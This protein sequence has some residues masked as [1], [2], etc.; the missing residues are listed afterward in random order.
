MKV[1]DCT[2]ELDNLGKRTVEVSVEANELIEENELEAI[3][4]T[5]QY[6]VLKIAPGN[7]DMNILMSKRQYVFT[8][9][10]FSIYKKLDSSLSL[11]EN[12]QRIY[13][14]F[15]MREVSSVSDVISQLSLSMFRTDRIWIDPDFGPEYSLRRYSNWIKTDVQKM[16]SKLY[17]LI[18]QGKEVGFCMLQH[19][20]K[21]MKV[22]LDGLYKQYQGQGLGCLLPFCGYYYKENFVDIEDYVT[23]ISS[24]NLGVLHTYNKCDFNMVG[25]NYVF[26]KH[27]N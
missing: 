3:E 12:Q 6:V 18:Y 22:V 1:V 17:S 4:Q 24:N 27:I 15:E 16:L 8:E 14:D 19:E 25:A 7:M 13:K 10:Q 21:R 26:I 23:T 11:N 9:S 2:W 20:D 5:Y